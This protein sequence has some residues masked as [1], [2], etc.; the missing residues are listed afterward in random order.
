M[1]PIRKKREFNKGSWG[2]HALP[3]NKTMPDKTAA[4]RRVM[5][6]RSFSNMDRTTHFLV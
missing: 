3:E 1:M 4:N 2:S 5:W 6:M